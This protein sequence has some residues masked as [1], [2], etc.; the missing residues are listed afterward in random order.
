MRVAVIHWWRWHGFP[1]CAGIGAALLGT[2]A[3][4]Y[5][6]LCAEAICAFPM[7]AM[8]GIGIWLVG[9]ELLDD[10]FEGD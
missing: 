9:Y 8:G 1:I 4:L 5:L 7:G 2:T 6:G 10:T 3:V